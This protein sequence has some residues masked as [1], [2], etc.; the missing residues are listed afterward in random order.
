MLGVFS[1]Y[2]TVLKRILLG[3]GATHLDLPNIFFHAATFYCLLFIIRTQTTKETL[4]KSLSD[5][6][7]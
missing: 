1:P 7:L 3:E 6:T 4:I 2:E 5:L